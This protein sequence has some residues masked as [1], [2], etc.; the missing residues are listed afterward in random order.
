[1]IR[2]L[3]RPVA[4]ILAFTLPL[5]AMAAAELTD[6]QV[7]L[8]QALPPVSKIEAALPK[9][10]DPAETAV[11][12]MMVLQQ[13]SEMAASIAPG[14]RDRELKA[15]VNQYH[16]ALVAGLPE[17]ERLLNG[18]NADELSARMYSD[19]R[20]G[21]KVMRGVYERTLEG[22]LRKYAL[23]YFDR[24]IHVYTRR[25]P[26]NPVESYVAELPEPWR[27]A[28]EK[29]LA[30][31][32]AVWIALLVLWLVL[33]IARRTAPFR[34]LPENPWTL[35][36]GGK[37]RSMTFQQV[38]VE[39]VKEMVRVTPW[40]HTPRDAQG[41]RSGPDQVSETRTHTLTLFVR[42]IDGRETS[43][44]LVNHDFDVRRGHRLLA[45][46]EDDKYCL[47]LY[48]HDL[49]KYLHLPRMRKFV[50]MR[51]WLLIP[52]WAL[53]TLLTAAISP[54]LSSLALVLTPILYL[55]LIGILNARRRRVF[56]KSMAPRLVQEAG[57]PPEHWG[58]VRPVARES[59]VA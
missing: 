45:V 28:A 15:K 52:V 19:L 31:P 38:L 42:G 2:D 26:A 11:D 53:T 24:Q 22:D 21:W 20:D 10:S 51:P 47:F 13:F 1:M 30:V 44:K 57:P 49:R 17:A 16:A 18:R 58:A 41:N 40:I 6:E 33:G 36:R 39:D 46:W 3:F 4:M 43:L 54:G 50:K 34:L 48:N 7:R 55:V 35:Q 23:D 8:I 56:M 14:L 29:V 25:E 32:G 5:A 9:R 12:R 37:L 27:T 59:V